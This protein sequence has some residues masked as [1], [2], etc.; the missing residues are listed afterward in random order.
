MTAN[1]DQAGRITV[2]FA[3]LMVGLAVFFGLSLN[4]SQLF[5]ER[6]HLQICADSAAFSGAVQQ[7]RGLN[8]IARMN[9]EAVKTLKTTKGALMCMVYP[10]HAAGQRAAW[11]AEAAYRIYNIVNLVNQQKASVEAVKDARQTA[12]EVTRRNEPEAKVTSYV[13]LAWGLGRLIPAKGT[14]ADFGFFFKQATPLGE[15]LMYDPGRTVNALVLR[16]ALQMDTIGFTAQVRRPSFPWLFSWGRTSQKS[17]RNLRAYASAKPAGG[18]L[19]MDD[20]ADPS[21]R[22]KLVLTASLFPQPLIPD[23]WGYAW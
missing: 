10:N 16:K 11:T 7:A 4:V 22:A 17:V 15:I 3:F 8:R 13:P 12:E 14:K 6:A 18:A 20:S 9:T 5:Q 19:W 21:Y 23:S 1:A 2:V